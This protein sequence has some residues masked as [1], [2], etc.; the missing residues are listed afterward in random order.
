MRHRFSS[1][2]LPEADRSPLLREVLARARIGCEI[3]PL[4]ET[5]LQ[6]ELDTLALGQCGAGSGCYS[7]L[8]AIRGEEHITGKGLM[9][10]SGAGRFG[11]SVA[12]GEVMAA[13]GTQVT[14]MPL[15]RPSRWI[16]DGPQAVSSI[17]IE[18][19]ALA[20]IAP[21]L[22]L[23]T[24]RLL[25]TEAPGLALLLAYGH[26]LHDHPPQAGVAALAGRHLTELAAQV[27]GGQAAPQGGR[28]A[29][30]AAIRRDM[31]GNFRDPD[32]DIAALARRHRISTRYLQMLFAEAGCSASDRLMALRLDAARDRLADPRRQAE[33]IGTIA[34]AC[35]F[36]DLS[37]FGRAFRRRF[38]MTPREFRRGG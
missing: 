24:P 22:D 5:P 4:G 26:A 21:G 1:R 31:A 2:D 10:S 25:T 15:H 28:A 9:I 33:R 35:G 14:V 17:W 32:L 6:I 16:Y 30:L 7:P 38:G 18:G 8:Q 37:N 19:A 36:R 12:G 23:D 3:A 27:L 34:F 11:V 20:E 13:G 29:R